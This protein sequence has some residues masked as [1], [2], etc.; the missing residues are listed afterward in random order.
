MQT[1]DIIIE[2]E[3]SRSIRC[4][5]LESM[6]DVPTQEKQRLE[7]KGAIDIDEKDWNVGLIVGPSGSGK[8]TIAKR[9]FGDNYNPEFIWSSDAVIDDFDDRF[10]INDIANVCQA[11][12]FNTIP[13]WMRPYDV[14]SNGERFRVDIARRLLELDDPIT[15]DEFTSVVD[16]Q[17]AKIASYAVQ[18]YIRHN[19]RQLIAI[20][21]HHDVNEW[22]M[23]D[24]IL[25]PAS[26]KYTYGR[27]L[28]RRP[29]LKAEIRRVDYEAWEL[30]APFH[31]LTNKLHKSARCYGLFINDEIASFAGIL[32]K[33]HPKTKNLYGVS[34]LVTLP[35]WQGI[36]L[37]MILVEKLGAMHKALGHRLR[38]YPAHPSLI[39]SFGKSKVWALKQKPGYNSNT[40]YIRDQNRYKKRVTP[41]DIS[42][43]EGL[44]PNAVFEYC[45]PVIDR[46]IAEGVLI[47]V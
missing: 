37:A 32:Y 21:C 39:R 16:R 15:I 4:R 38:T 25:Q 35:D 8:S 28:Q 24:W 1:I 9:L 27:A 42:K 44:R 20:S 19:N 12:G 2:S 11:V 29:T 23:P 6:F 31:Y 43:S 41:C 30:F 36:G 17:V 33:P 13:A 47:G 3:I 26:M 22:L 45:G 46:E 5:Q 18:K 7:W 14:L 34:R 40:H 10:K